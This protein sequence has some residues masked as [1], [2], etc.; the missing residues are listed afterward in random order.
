MLQSRASYVVLGYVVVLHY[1][2]E[3]A[4]WCWAMWWCFI[5]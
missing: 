3:L 4:K 5:M 1:V 2:A